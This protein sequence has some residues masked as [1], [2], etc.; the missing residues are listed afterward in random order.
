MSK[1]PGVRRGFMVTAVLA[2]AATPA[3]FLAPLSE[4]EPTKDSEESWY[5]DAMKAVEAQEWSTGEG[6]TVAVIDTGVD[7]AHPDLE[8][9]VLE[10][11]TVT[12]DGVE[13]GAAGDPDGHGT[14]MAGLIAGENDDGEL[15]GVAPD[16]EILP[17]RIERREDGSLDQNLVYEGVRWAI[18][19]GATV[20]NLSLAG[21]P[22]AD[23]DGWKRDL[24]SY[25]VDNN[26]VIVAAV[27]N[28]TDFESEVGEPAS[29]PGVLAVSGMG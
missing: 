12:E 20:I 8:G 17:V 1:K 9:R 15:T 13:P 10:G 19:E 25:A 3:L 11:A 6:V 7:A 21:K 26:A 2:V 18:D 23:D 16:S 22:T 14:A 28:R 29:I 24:I 5:L 4:A 27:G